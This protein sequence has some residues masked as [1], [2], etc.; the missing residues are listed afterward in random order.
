ML[1]VKLTC[2]GLLFCF[3]GSDTG[4][5][6]HISNSSLQNI[7]CRKY[8]IVPLPKPAPIRE[9]HAKRHNGPMIEETKISL[10]SLVWSHSE[11]ENNKRIFFNGGVLS[12]NQ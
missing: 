9:M 11:E 2:I 12:H 1:G 4:A 10:G 7:E 3:S 5:I 6:V 8:R